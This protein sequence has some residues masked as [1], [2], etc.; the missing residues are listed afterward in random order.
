[1]AKK[2]SKKSSKASKAR[3][4]GQQTKNK[5]AKAKPTTPGKAQDK[6]PNKKSTKP[7]AD[8]EKAQ[9]RTPKAAP[10]ETPQTPAPRELNM[11]FGFGILGVFAILSLLVLAASWKGYQINRHTVAAEAARA[12]HRYLDAVEHLSYIVGVYPG[13]YE[14]W[15]QLGD[16]YLELAEQVSEGKIKGDQKK[17]A[18]D[19]LKAYDQVITSDVRGGENMTELSARR[20]QAYYLQGD[21]NNAL[22]LLKEAVKADDRDPHANYYIGLYHL[23]KKQYR[24]ATQFL[25][26]AT[27]D[28]NLRRKI[29]PRLETIRKAV[30]V[31]EAAI[32]DDAT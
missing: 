19:A 20:G 23:E 16:A 2:S 3:N 21:L 6:S 30:F 24:L 1:M 13:A 29:D 31:S 17:L 10:E 4:K 26:A 12:D 18:S 5:Q 8:T 11:R 27:V 32:A 14:R 28:E 25:E 9:Q 22:L 15:E 7:A